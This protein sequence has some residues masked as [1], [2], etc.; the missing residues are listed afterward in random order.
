MFKTLVRLPSAFTF[1]LTY[2]C[3]F[4]SMLLKG[5]LN[6]ENSKGMS[7]RQLKDMAGVG[8]DEVKT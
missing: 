6:T 1:T 8:W 7:T 2:S 4:I 5:L 3:L